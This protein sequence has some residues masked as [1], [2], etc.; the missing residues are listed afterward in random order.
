MTNPEEKRNLTNQPPKPLDQLKKFMYTLISEQNELENPDTE[1]IEELRSLSTNLLQFPT[2][3][4]TLSR[5]AEQPKIL[6]DHSLQMVQA[7]RQVIAETTNHLNKHFRIYNDKFSRHTT[8]Y[9]DENGN[10]IDYPTL[11]NITLQ[12]INTKSNLDALP[13]SPTPQ[14]VKTVLSNLCRFTV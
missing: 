7:G 11:S 10:E 3:I 2:L 8:T 12:L 14:Q 9:K 4:S 6:Q 13:Q 5:D 1:F